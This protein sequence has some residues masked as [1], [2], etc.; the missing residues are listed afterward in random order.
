MLAS[1]LQPPPNLPVD[2][3]F[4]HCSSKL[5]TLVPHIKAQ[6][7]LELLGYILQEIGGR[8]D[9]L[10][11]QLHLHADDPLRRFITRY[12]HGPTSPSP[13]LPSPDKSS[14]ENESASTPVDM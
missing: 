12:Q 7:R 2:W 11:L 9:K 3:P 1:P 14:G 10:L 6:H 4:P 5:V 8:H 13:P